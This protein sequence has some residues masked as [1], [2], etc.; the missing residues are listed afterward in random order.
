M[1]KFKK[2]GKGANFDFLSFK[3]DDSLV[4]KEIKEIIESSRDELTIV[5]K[6]TDH[7]KS[8]WLL[9]NGWR[10]RNK[11]TYFNAVKQINLFQDSCFLYD[12]SNIITMTFINIL[13]S[14]LLFR[15]FLWQNRRS[16]DRFDNRKKR[17]I[18]FYQKKCRKKI[19]R[20]TNCKS[21][22]E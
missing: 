20:L 4:L 21:K 6:E 14:Y 1:P 11:K 22:W 10:N 16:K 3:I 13:A 17:Q 19:S 15:K 2:A 12:R 18:F 7:K 8:K 9:F 5:E